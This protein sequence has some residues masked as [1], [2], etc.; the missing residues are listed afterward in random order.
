MISILSEYSNSTK[1]TFFSLFVAILLTLIAMFLPIIHEHTFRFISFKI[2]I[3]VSLIYSIYILI[4][5]SIPIIK[6]EKTKLLAN[7]NTPLRRNMIY[8]TILAIAIMIY[9]WHVVW[10]SI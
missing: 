1:H 10:M 8:N 5:K 6:S 3:L 4:S 2:L 7:G 9:M